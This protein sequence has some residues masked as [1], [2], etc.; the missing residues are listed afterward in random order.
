M[1]QYCISLI[2]YLEYYRS[3]IIILIMNNRNVTTNKPEYWKMTHF[4]FS[5]HKLSSHCSHVIIQTSP[6]LGKV[7]KNKPCYP[8]LVHTLREI[9]VFR[10]CSCC[11]C[12]G[13][14][15]HFL[16]FIVSFV[17]KKKF[18]AYQPM[19]SKTVSVPHVTLLIY[20]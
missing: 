20:I 10:I 4:S 9:P 16:Q 19:K 1:I 17:S 11:L 5:L 7:H 12:S 2:H 14:F 15:N 6:F 3:Q 18:R 13:W 8:N